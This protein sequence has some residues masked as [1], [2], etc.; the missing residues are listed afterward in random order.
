MRLKS[1]GTEKTSVHP[2]ST[3]LR[4]RCLPK[5]AVDLTMGYTGGDD[6]V[7]AFDMPVVEILREDAEDADLGE[8]AILLDLPAVA[9]G[10]K[11]ETCLLN[12]GEPAA[13]RSAAFTSRL[14]LC[15]GLWAVFAFN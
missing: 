8:A 6:G 1:P 14:P 11:T 7:V 13:L 9:P 3:N 12:L 10:T 4:A 15:D 5:H 2:I